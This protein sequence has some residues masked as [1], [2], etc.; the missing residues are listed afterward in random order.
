VAAA[1]SKVSNENFASL[2]GNSATCGIM[3]HEG[4]HGAALSLRHMKN[5]SGEPIAEALDLE[6]VLSC[7]RH[8]ARAP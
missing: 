4:C 2:A 6:V 8:C 1:A 3:I 5:N 7:S